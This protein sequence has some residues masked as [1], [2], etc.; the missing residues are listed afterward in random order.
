MS[1]LPDS[2]GSHS[3]GGAS[4]PALETK[5][6]ISSKRHTKGEYIIVYIPPLEKGGRG[7]SVALMVA[8]WLNILIR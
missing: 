5:E 6:L 1:V 8:V 4:S 2:N 7:N 3:V